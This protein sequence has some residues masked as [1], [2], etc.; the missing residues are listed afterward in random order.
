MMQVTQKER[1][2]VDRQKCRQVFVGPDKS[3]RIDEVIYRFPGLRNTSKFHL[4]VL[5]SED[6]NRIW[7]NN[8][9]YWKYTFE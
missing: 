7:K 6:V 2:Y 3:K 4:I 1:E 9:A 8:K 5:V